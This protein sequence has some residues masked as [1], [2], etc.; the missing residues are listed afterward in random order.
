MLPTIKDIQDLED[1]RVLV[2]VDWSVP[3]VNGEVESEYQIKES[4]PTIEYL[5]D[6]GAKVIIATHLEHEEDSIESL[7][8][9]VPEGAEILDNLR[10][11]P[12]EKANDEA[13]AKELASLADIYVN[14]AFP[15]S[16]RAHASVVGV[17]KFIPGYLGFGIE[18][19]IENLS[20]AFNPEHPFLFILGGAKFDT[21]LP[22]INKFLHIADTVF[23]GGALANNFFR[24]QG[25]DI[26]KSYVSEGAFPTKELWDTG[27]I[28]LPEDYAWKEER[29]VDAGPKTIEALKEKI[30]QSETILWNGPLGEYE[31]GAQEW[32]LALAKVLSESGKKVI[33]GGGD[34]L[35][36][37][38]ELNL[39]D[40]FFF[41]ST[42][43]GAMLDFLANET[44][45]G[46]E[47][48]KR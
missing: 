8:K 45:P 27:K 10:K 13:F 38:R 22:L 33:V 36:A 7:R 47:A 4:L 35:A 24:D 20:R 21:K 2:R 40:K 1:K 28:M 34:T 39:F 30:D 11:K 31:K 32:T 6:R 41:V 23:V 18:K 9:Y 25:M 46:I 29:I 14:D 3:L 37:I 12:G 5:Q 19:E 43:G 15:V 44:L 48:L 26:K 16:H 42:G 17:P